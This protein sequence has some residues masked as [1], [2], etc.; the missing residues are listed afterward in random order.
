MLPWDT[1]TTGHT[2]RQLGI[3]KAAAAH[4][5]WIHK[6]S[7]LSVKRIRSHCHNE[8]PQTLSVGVATAELQ[9]PQL[10]PKPPPIAE[11]AAEF[12]PPKK[13]RIFE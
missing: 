1:G 12:Y 4:S 2:S 5:L 13:I 10:D 9:L 3:V 11:F 6:N 7:S 8:C